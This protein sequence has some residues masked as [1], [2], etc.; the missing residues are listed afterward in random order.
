M[1][2]TYIGSRNV[3]LLLVGALL[4]VVSTACSDREDATSGATLSDPASAELRSFAAEICS[5]QSSGLAHNLA[6]LADR[7]EVIEGEDYEARAAAVDSFLEI[8][9]ARS[10]EDLAQL[11]AIS[12]PTDELAFVDGLRANELEF[13]TSITDLQRR[14]QAASSNGE[15]DLVLEML[16]DNLGSGVNARDALAAASP[17][18]EQALRA[19]ESCADLF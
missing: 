10:L 17:D 15:L 8:L 19:D 3:S 7:S 14:A 2:S 16:I 18:L 13:G 12:A 1:D 5:I 6:A 9:L 4:L 11:S